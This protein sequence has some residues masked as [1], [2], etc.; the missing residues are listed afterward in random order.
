MLSKIIYINKWTWI[1]IDAYQN[2]R[3]N[4]ITVCEIILFECVFCEFKNQFLYYLWKTEKADIRYHF[5]W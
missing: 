4:S 1:I 2:H 3:Q 5:I